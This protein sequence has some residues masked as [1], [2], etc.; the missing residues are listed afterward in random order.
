MG[1][2]S[3]ATEIN[4]PSVKTKE[5]LEL[6]EYCKQH[7]GVEPPIVEKPLRSKV[8]KEVCKDPWDAEYIDRI[9][10]DRQLLYDVILVRFIIV[11]FFCSQFRFP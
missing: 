9:G 6:V 4:V 10:E 1:Q 8:M 11:L 5:M 3:N 2:D 7:K